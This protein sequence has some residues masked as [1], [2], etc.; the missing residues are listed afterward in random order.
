MLTILSKDLVSNL[1]T[2]TQDEIE[3]IHGDKIIASVLNSALADTDNPAPV[4]VSPYNLS[5]KP[6]VSPTLESHT[7]DFKFNSYPAPIVNIPIRTTLFIFKSMAL[8]YKTE[9]IP[10]PVVDTLI[11]LVSSFA[12]DPIRILILIGPL[13][14]LWFQKESTLESGIKLFE[15]EIISGVET[16]IPQSYILDSSNFPR[17]K[18]FYSPLVPRLM[19]KS[20]H[21]CSYFA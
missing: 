6:T 12:G 2:S 9:G 16:C 19:L 20:F 18:N 14:A 3:R 17:L 11:G 10:F 1:I 4:S 21:Y 7:V 5:A 8:V 15:K 13:A